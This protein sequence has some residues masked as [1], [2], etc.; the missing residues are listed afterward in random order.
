[1]GRFGRCRSTGGNRSY[2]PFTVDIPQE[3]I[4]DLRL[5]LEE[6]R[7]PGAATTDDWSQG[8][9]LARMQELAAYWRNDYDMSRLQTR[10]NAYPQFRTR[11]DGL[12]I[13]FLHVRSPH[14]DAM[15]ILLTHGW[16][17]SVLEFLNL[18]G[19]LTDPT[20]H[21]GRA[22]DAFHVVIPSLP[23]FGFSDKPAEEGWNVARIATAWGTLMQRLGYDKW[24]AQGGDWGRV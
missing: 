8:V 16:P 13:H 12:G 17:G 2:H 18:I 19:P 9:P 14:A 3:A 22:E 15:P 24:V 20:A 11:I 1:M 5:R 23:G 7:W 10:L 6:T 21:G 4:A